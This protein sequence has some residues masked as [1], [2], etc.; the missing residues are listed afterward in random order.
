MSQRVHGALLPAQLAED[1]NIVTSHYV[2][3]SYFY[4][5]PE[6]IVDYK[7]YLTLFGLGR[8]GGGGKLAPEGFC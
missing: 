1:G 3:S 4:L 2:V 6:G 8:W 7:V 5:F